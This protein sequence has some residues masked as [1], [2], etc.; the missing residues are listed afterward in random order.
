MILQI[1]TED[2]IVIVRINGTLDLFSIHGMAPLNQHLV[3][4]LKFSFT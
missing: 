3:L 4:M 1:V 2:V